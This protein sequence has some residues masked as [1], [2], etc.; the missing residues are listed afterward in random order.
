MDEWRELKELCENGYELVFRGKQLEEM[1]Q[2]AKFKKVGDVV[3]K[4]VPKVEEPK[5]EEKGEE[6]EKEK[7]EEG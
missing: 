1:G 6:E 5:I 3:V 4:R 2:L 7:E